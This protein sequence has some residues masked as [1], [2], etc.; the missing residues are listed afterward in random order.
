ML[1]RKA[2]AGESGNNGGSDDMQFIGERRRPKDCY[3]Q[4]KDTQERIIMG[5]SGFVVGGG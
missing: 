5:S 2:G 1:R 3:N 4:R